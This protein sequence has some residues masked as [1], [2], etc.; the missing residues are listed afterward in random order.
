MTLAGLKEGSIFLKISKSLDSDPGSTQQLDSINFALL[1]A[2]CQ[3]PEGIIVKG[4]FESNL[5]FLN[6]LMLCKKYKLRGSNEDKSKSHRKIYWMPFT[7]L[8][9]T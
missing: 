6:S 3:Y 2:L 9:F 8:T 5:I 1:L 4:L 7:N